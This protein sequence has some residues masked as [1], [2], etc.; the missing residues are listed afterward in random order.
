MPKESINTLPPNSMVGPWIL[1][2]RFCATASGHFSVAMVCAL[3]M[4]A[5]L[6]HV[7]TYRYLIPVFSA[8]PLGAL[9]GFSDESAV[10]CLLRL[11]SS[12]VLCL[13]FARIPWVWLRWLG[14]LI[15]CLLG[16][17][18]FLFNVSQGAL[19]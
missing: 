19:L 18:M 14:S 4:G 9:Y 11:L 3:V 2:R 7:D 5:E 15:W 1:V 8:G 17:S 13:F 6:F 10:L 16:I 12:L